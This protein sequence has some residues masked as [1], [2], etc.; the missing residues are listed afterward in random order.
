MSGT[1]GLPFVD[2]AS[3]ICRSLHH[4]DKDA[5]YVHNDSGSKPF[6]RAFTST[7]RPLGWSV[8]PRGR[9]TVDAEDCSSCVVNGRPLLMICDVGDNGCKRGAYHMYIMEEPA[10]PNPG[11]N[12]LQLAHKLTWMYPD[13]KRRNCEAVTMLSSG[14]IVVVTKSWPEKSGPTTLFEIQSVLSDSALATSPVAITKHSVLPK[15][16]G[17]VTG[18]DAMVRDGVEHI[19]LLGIVRGNSMATI[20]RA[21]DYTLVK[22]FRVPSARQN[23]GICFSHDGKAVIT[24]SEV[25]R[26]IQTT[27]IPM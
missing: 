5:Y 25:D 18:M 9:S 15:S 20:L 3:G 17:I 19:V 22:T 13:G 14:K 16:Y 21:D 8:I 7:G 12:A 11:D 27:R 26:K 23:E 2:E 1:L 10:T 6:L 24:V 4:A